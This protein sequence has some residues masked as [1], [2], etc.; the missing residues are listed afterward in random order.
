MISR[1][2]LA[3]VVAAGLA[4]V[5]PALAAAQLPGIG[6]IGRRLPAALKRDSGIVVPQTIN[7][8]NLVVQH[9][10][11]IA[12]TDTQ[13]V[14]II[15][16]KRALDSTNAP[17]SRRIDSVQRL[18]KGVPIFTEP[19]AAHRD[20]LNAGKAVI[21][22]MTADIDDNIA[23]AKDKMFALLTTPQKEQAE[24]VEDKAR[25]ASAAAGRGRL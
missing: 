23:D 17:L 21:K 19:T 13:F 7:V 11:D 22:E 8:V 25:K 15:A 10:Q 16:I 14:R 3:I 9:R 1:W 24:Q 2:R 5:A 6:S 12:L 4:S 20:S 18:F